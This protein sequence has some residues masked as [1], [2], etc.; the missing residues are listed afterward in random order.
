MINSNHNEI[1]EKYQYVYC[2]F[3]KK[4]VYVVWNNENQ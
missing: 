2:T 1:I 4:N 3:I